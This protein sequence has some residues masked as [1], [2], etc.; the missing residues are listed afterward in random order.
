MFHVEEPSVLLK[1]EDISL[2]EKKKNI[3]ARCFISLHACVQSF[4]AQQLIFVS[5]LLRFEN[6]ISQV[7]GRPPRFILSHPVFIFFLVVISSYFSFSFLIFKNISVFKDSFLCLV[8][9]HCFAWIFEL[10]SAEADDQRLLLLRVSYVF[11]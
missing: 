2:N 8:I 10:F 9:I 3:F 7:F 4:A 5:F 11:N 1:F 6:L